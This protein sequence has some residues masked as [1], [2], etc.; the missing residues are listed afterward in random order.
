VGSEPLQ[1]GRKLEGKVA[2]VTGAGSSGPGVGTGKAIS[3]LFAREGAAL[4][5]VDKVE[6]RAKETLALVEA[7]GAEATVVTVDLAEIASGQQVIDQAVATFGGVDVLVNNAAI[8]STTGILD[9]TP[10]LYQQIVAVNLT[11]PF[12]LTKAALPVLVERGGGAIVNVISIAA[13]RGQGGVGQTAYAASKAGLVGLMVDVAD[14][15]GQHGVRVNCVA[16]GIIDT[17]MRAAAI[18]QAGRDPSTIDLG[19]RTALG[20]EGDAWDI[21]RAALFLAGPDGRFVTGVVLPVD[22]G[23][24][25]ISR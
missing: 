8:P 16:P 18:R 9:T 12:M 5:L 19:H 3:V 13:L 10:E 25:A 21:A 20:I 17:P 4:V 2:V 11:A 1:S 22:G 14:T 24:T 23:T 7:E 15:F 6:D